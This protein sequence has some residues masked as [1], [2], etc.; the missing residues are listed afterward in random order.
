MPAGLPRLTGIMIGPFGRSAI[1]AS[2]GGKPIVV[3]EGGHIGR[4]I[5][6]LIKVGEVQVVGPDGARSLRPSFQ[7]SPSSVAQPVVIGER[8]GLT[9]AL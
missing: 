9:L 8:I 7:S 6:R 3:A 4:W 5:V 2:D 1:F